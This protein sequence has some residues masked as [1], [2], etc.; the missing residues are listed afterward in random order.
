MADQH[1][2]ARVFDA[3]IGGTHIDG[4]I[5]P[6]IGNRVGGHRF[7]QGLLA[8]ADDAELPIATAAPGEVVNASV[9]AEPMTLNTA[10]FV[11]TMLPLAGAAASIFGPAWF[12][13]KS[14]KCAMPLA[15]VER[16]NVP[17]KVPVPLASEMTIAAFVSGWPLMSN[18]CT[19]TS[20]VMF[21][22]GR[23]FDGCCKN[24]IVSTSGVK[25]AFSVMGALIVT[26]AALFVPEYEPLPLPLQPP[27]V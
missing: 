15:S 7:G 3:S 26:E 1:F 16:V 5:E 17:A 6:A 25:L 12:K 19:W 27:N 20:G 4:G 24:S 11:A 13:L 2:H 23:T 14:L 8:V 22:P 10:L 18:A 9:T 21:A